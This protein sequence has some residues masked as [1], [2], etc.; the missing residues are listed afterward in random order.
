MVF[1]FV[2]TEITILMLN[3]GIIELLTSTESNPYRIAFKDVQ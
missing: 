2:L 3:N 1:I